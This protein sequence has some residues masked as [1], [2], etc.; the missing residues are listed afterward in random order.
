MAGASSGPGCLRIVTNAARDLGRRKGRRPALRLVDLDADDPGAPGFDPPIDDDPALG[1]ARQDL[2]RLLDS[3][4]ER[5]SP[6]LRETFVLFAEAELSY[7]EIADCQ[8]IPIG[9]VMSRMNSARQKLQA[10]ID[11]DA[12]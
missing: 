7:Q 2:R 12:G 6:R 9:T 3:A 8:G 1:L 11:E 10:L 5:L 4:L